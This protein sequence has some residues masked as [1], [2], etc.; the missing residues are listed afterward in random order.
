M[1]EER[2]CSPEV[3]KLLREKGFDIPVLTRYEDNGEVIF[4]ET[5]VV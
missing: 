3:A 2:C 5:Y 4:G 1:I